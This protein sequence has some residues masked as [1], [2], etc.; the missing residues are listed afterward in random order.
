MR[1]GQLACEL[2]GSSNEPG[3]DILVVGG[4]RPRAMR[5]A[6]SG[7]TRRAALGATS[8]YVVRAAHCT[9]LV[10]R[11]DRFPTGGTAAP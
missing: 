7:A 11:G 5:R 10:V 4:G 9:V 8:D 1:M 2:V 3:T 6:V